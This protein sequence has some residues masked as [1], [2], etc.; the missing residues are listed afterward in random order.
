MSRPAFRASP[1]IQW[2]WKLV[3]ASKTA[4]AWGWPTISISCWVWERNEL[5]LHLFD[6]VVCTGTNLP[7]SLPFVYKMFMRV[8]QL[9][10]YCSKSAPDR[11]QVSKFSPCLTEKK[12]NVSVIML[13]WL[14]DFLENY[15]CL[16]VGTCLLG[17]RIALSV[18]LLARRHGV[19]V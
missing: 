4:R 3:F 14:M 7:V 12:Q 15:L 2:Y 17:V 9:S 11:N 10:C 13:I 6:F 19:L 8:V 1:P 5:Q 16:F 18:I